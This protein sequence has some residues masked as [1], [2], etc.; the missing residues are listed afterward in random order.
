MARKAA[1]AAALQGEGSKPKRRPAKIQ[2][3]S[4]ARTPFAPGQSGRL[5]PPN[6]G[7]VRRPSEAAFP[8]RPAGPALQRKRAQK[9]DG[10]ERSITEKEGLRTQGAHVIHIA[11]L[12]AACALSSTG[13][14]FGIK[15]RGGKKD[16]RTMTPTPR[17]HQ[18]PLGKNPPFGPPLPSI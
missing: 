9:G 6:P 13:R 5:R 10:R 1:A 17:T 4:A 15:R 12:H 2:R 8:P 7:Q 3:F 16:S 14:R 18:R 11:V